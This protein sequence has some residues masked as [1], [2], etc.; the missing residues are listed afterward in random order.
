M[1]ASAPSIA[2][3]SHLDLNLARFR[4]P[5]MKA[6]LES[7]WRVTAIVPQ[8]PYTEAI[9]TLGV[10]VLD[11]PATRNQRGL[12]AHLA[13]RKA[14]KRLFRQHHFD[15][16]HSFTHLPNLL[17]RLA[18][19]WRKRPIL[20]NSITGL[21]SGFIK[22]GVRGIAMRMVLYQAYARTSR[23]CDAV[24]FQNEDDHT[25]FTWRGLT[26]KA[27]THII[28]GSGVD[29]SLFRPGLLS[30]K[31]RQA[32]RESLGVKPKHVMA[33]MAS[34]LLYDK[35]IREAMLAAT[36]LLG[37]SPSIRLVVAGAPDAG[38]PASMTEEDLATF[39]GLGNV[40]FTGWR[41]DMAALWNAADMAI[42]PSY[43]EGLPVSLQEALACGLPVI[44]TDAPG[45]REIARSHLPGGSPAGEANDPD[46]G[47]EQE[48]FHRGEHAILIPPSQWP[49]LAEA[50]RMVAE[51]PKVRAAMS[52]A[53]RAKAEAD[54]DAAKLA[55]QTIAVYEALLAK[56]AASVRRRNR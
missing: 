20:V 45:C 22:K 9:V 21:G 56:R 1:T 24:L 34:R 15:V 16:V 2:L 55:R 11:Y 14:L 25:Y 19:P 41:E 49:P 17:C 27:A 28:P 8:G 53:A 29:L 48:A 31:K 10:E 36:G 3:V 18:L 54:F 46:E 30:P 39:S 13:A 33:V 43:R 4:T 40:I 6:L 32:L 26:G 12:L 47:M 23:R 42:L 37:K 52:A 5:L 7:G 50:M 38:N 35:G 44:T 51:N